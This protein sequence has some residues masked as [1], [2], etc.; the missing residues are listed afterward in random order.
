MRRTISLLTVSILWLCYL[1]VYA[2][3]YNADSGELSSGYMTILDE[4]DQIIMQTGLTIYPGDQYISEDNTCYEIA[5]VE[6]NLAKAYYIEKYSTADLSKPVQSVPTDTTGIAIYHTHTDES[7]IPTNGTATQ[8]GQGSILAVGDT[9]A[10]RLTALG[11]RVYHSKNLHDPHDANAYQRSRRTFMSLLANRPNA[12]FDVHR[13]SAPINIY[14]TS[15]N[16]QQAVKILLVVGKQNQ[17]EQTSLSYA[18]TIKSAADAKYKGLIRGIFIGQGNYNQDLDPRAML[19]EV[20]TQYNTLETA[21]HS[22]ALFADVVPSFLLTGTPQQTSALSYV[23]DTT[24]V[25]G[26]SSID[27]G[28]DIFA[29][30]LA[31]VMGGM[32]FLYLSTGNWREAK[33]KLKWLRDREFND[34]LPFRKKN[35]R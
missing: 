25:T 26:P 8:S 3:G 12:F 21:Q 30:I 18:K 16:G 19:I 20:G 13:D 4:Q 31:T 15:I 9:L 11:Y 10:Q 1:P 2:F 7:Y 23:T 35:K 32:I 34:L 22:I 28:F 33:Q 14:Q 6:G 17:N 5:A 29:I 27:Y 24:D